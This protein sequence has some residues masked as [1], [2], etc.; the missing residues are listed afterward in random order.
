MP[1]DIEVCS[2]CGS[3]YEI[4]YKK[5]SHR[6]KDSIDCN[7]CGSHLIAWNGSVMAECHLM[8]LHENHLKPKSTL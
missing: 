1:K 5:I 3:I 2:K 6:D 7:V 4:H 8:E